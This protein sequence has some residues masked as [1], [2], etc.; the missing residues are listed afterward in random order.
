MCSEL[1]VDI[2]HRLMEY[3]GLV[4]VLVCI[5]V[6]LGWAVVYMIRRLVKLAERF[7]EAFKDSTKAQIADTNTNRELVE[8]INELIATDKKG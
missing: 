2:G 5:S 7:L 3:G 1:F 8:R 6:F 4:I